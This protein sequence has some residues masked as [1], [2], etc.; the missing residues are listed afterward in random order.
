MKTTH[1]ENMDTD[2]A[3]GQDNKKPP[4]W[5]KKTSDTRTDTPS[6][7]HSLNMDPYYDKD[8]IAK[9][10]KCRLCGFEDAALTTV[11]EHV[12]VH[13]SPSTATPS[14]CKRQAKEETKKKWLADPEFN[15]APQDPYRFITPTEVFCQKC[16]SH[17]TVIW[18]S[19][20]VKHNNSEKHKEN[21]RLKAKR[22]ALQLEAEGDAEEKIKLKAVRRS[23]RFQG[24]GDVEEKPVVPVNRLAKAFCKVWLGANIPFN[25]LNHPM[26]REF[27]ELNFGLVI[28]SVT[29]VKA[30][31]EV[32]YNEVMQVLIISLNL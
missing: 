1:G 3:K 22:R 28:P 16:E 9:V 4:W 13:T 17:F 6:T 23:L 8:L 10:Y 24:G 19:H 12:K 21:V 26:L 31:I 30:N 20:L 2:M 7:T 25:K 11:C 5:P 18:R 15:S 14:P 27:F 32:C 29:A